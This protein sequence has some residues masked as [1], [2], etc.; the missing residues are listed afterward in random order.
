MILGFRVWG[1]ERKSYKSL[2][3]F[4]PFR[5]A[6]S[7]LLWTGARQS[8]HFNI[9]AGKSKCNSKEKPN[10]KTAGVMPPEQKHTRSNVS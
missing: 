9:G 1:D 5:G 4:N 3:G 2:I 6:L 10:P 7:N 8:A